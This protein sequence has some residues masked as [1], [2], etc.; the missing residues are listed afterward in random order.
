MTTGTAGLDFRKICGARIEVR[1]QRN[2]Q[3]MYEW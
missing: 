2:F 1:K 3:G